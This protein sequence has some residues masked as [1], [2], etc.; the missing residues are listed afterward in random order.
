VLD[1]SRSEA[2]K[3]ILA[4]QAMDMRD[5]LADCASM[6]RE[7]CAAAGLIFEMRGMD[8]ALPMT[9]DPAKLRQIFLNLLSNA[10]TFTE[11]GGTIRLSAMALADNVAVTVCDTGIGM[12][13]DDVQIAFQPF[14]QVDSRLERRYEGTGLGL[15]LTKALVDLHQG[16]IVID[17]ARGQGTRVTV[18]FARTVTAGMAGVG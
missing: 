4:P 17:S 9:G 3:M 14:A 1:L 6:V 15:P 18:S 10:I 16:H 13:P 8:E 5:V 2:G 11:K 7:Q 12:D